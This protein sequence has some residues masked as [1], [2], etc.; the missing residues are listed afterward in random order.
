MIE[1]LLGVYKAWPWRSHCGAN[2]HVT[3]CRGL[4]WMLPSAK[5]CDAPDIP[6][7]NPLPR[8]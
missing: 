8:R 1:V 7:P 5:K 2:G 3:L 6:I 4:D